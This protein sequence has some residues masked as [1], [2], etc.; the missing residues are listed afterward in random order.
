MRSAWQWN[1]RRPRERQLL[2]EPR[3]QQLE[4]HS[5]SH[6]KQILLSQLVEAGTGASYYSR[7]PMCGCKIGQGSFTAG[8][9]RFSL[10][11]TGIARMKR[12]CFP[13]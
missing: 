5:Y 11:M 3:D 2:R 6:I 1:S 4:I 8:K 9:L 12:A 13:P 7:S 10:N